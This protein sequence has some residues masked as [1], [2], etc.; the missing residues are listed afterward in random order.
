MEVF[1]N[2]LVRGGIGG[3][4][5]DWNHNVVRNWDKCRRGVSD[6]SIWREGE[7]ERER[8]FNV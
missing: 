1:F 4:I 3:V 2:P 7:G 8:E 6:S 5:R